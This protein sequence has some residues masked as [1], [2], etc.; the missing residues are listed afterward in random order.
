MTAAGTTF[1]A[2]TYA[3]AHYAFTMVGEEP[4][5][6]EVDKKARAEALKH[7]MELLGKY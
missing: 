1:E 7:W 5:A 3:N 4:E 6:A 2:I